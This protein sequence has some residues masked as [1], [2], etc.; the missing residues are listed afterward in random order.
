MS[1][2]FDENG[3]RL[4][5]FD[6]SLNQLK[7]DFNEIYKTDDGEQIDFDSETP[8]GQA[9]NI[10]AQAG[11]IC[12]QTLSSV[13]ASFD[14]DQA[15]GNILD[16]RVKI[17]ALTR[18]SGT[19]TLV[20][21]LITTNKTVT[22]KGLDNTDITDETLYIVQD[23]A[24]NRYILLNSVTINANSSLSCRFRAETYGA[25]EVLPDTL[26]TP[27]TIVSGVVSVNNPLA[28]VIIG[29]AEESDSRLKIRRRRSVALAGGNSCDSIV[30]E[31]LDIDGIT[32]ARCYENY[33]QATGVPQF[34]GTDIPLHSIWLV[35]LGTTTGDDGNEDD[36][37]K[38]LYVKNGYAR[39][40]FTG[41]V[42][43]YSHENVVYQNPK[44]GRVF[45]AN[46]DEA[47]PLPIYLRF[48]VK[49][50]GVQT[51]IDADTQDAIKTLI[52]QNAEFYIAQSVLSS[53]FS[54]TIQNA[55]D[56][57]GVVGGV[58]LA[59]EFSTDNSTWSAYLD[60]DINKIFT[61]TEANIA[62]TVA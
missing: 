47:Q 20:D 11:E 54:A 55:V 8:D 48:T 34:N 15:S 62:I 7:Q 26:T 59:I 12:R 36:I 24:G 22:L 57:S 25:F 16:Q 39:P 53:D 61:L 10:F 30:A 46:W 32:D 49:M 33:G 27:V 14:P 21:V 38:A 3:L 52:V 42:A 41:Q 9:L 18:K 19:Y 58:A 37:A 4:Q 31:V 6:E 35:T 50:T 28:Q 51:T 44:T 1:D 60:C 29:T 56:S 2:T 43:G 17:N 5:T 40:M 23:D 45:Y 13:N